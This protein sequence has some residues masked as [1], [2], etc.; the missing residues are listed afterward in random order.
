M[1]KWKKKKI[2]VR[3]GERRV[4]PEPERKERVKP[5]GRRQPCIAKG[6]E[7]RRKK[8]RAACMLDAVQSQSKEEKRIFF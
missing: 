7:R 1:Q 8:Q 6:R 4:S 2:E 5:Q 3:E